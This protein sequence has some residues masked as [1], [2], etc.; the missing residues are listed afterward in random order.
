VIA[1]CSRED[2]FGAG[3]AS[4]DHQVIRL[5]EL[6][7]SGALDCQLFDSCDLDD[8]GKVTYSTVP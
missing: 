5:A 7:E 2:T 6:L 1:A 4:S 3:T 8:E